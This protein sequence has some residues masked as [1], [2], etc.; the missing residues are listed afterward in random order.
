MDSNFT[1]LRRD[2]TGQ[3]V[4]T[5]RAAQAAISPFRCAGR[6]VDVKQKPN[7][8]FQHL[9]DLGGRESK[10]PMSPCASMQIIPASHSFATCSLAVEDDPTNR[11]NSP[12]VYA[13]HPA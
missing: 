10:I 11:A 3:V 1:S 8:S 4:V 12:P 9:G 6:S 7:H 2:V 13:L 5:R